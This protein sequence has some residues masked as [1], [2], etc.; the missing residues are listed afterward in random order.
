MLENS[1]QTLTLTLTVK[2]AKKVTIFWKNICPGQFHPYA[3]DDGD[4]DISEV[5]LGGLYTF[6]VNASQSTQSVLHNNFPTTLDSPEYKMCH[7]WI[8][9][10]RMLCKVY[11]VGEVTL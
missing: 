7:D 5:I 4:D 1:C 6:S 10:F 2:V 11:E 8:T 9:T 3:Y